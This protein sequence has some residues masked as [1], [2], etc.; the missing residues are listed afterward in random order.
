MI[1]FAALPTA[2]TLS[3]TSNQS[4]DPARAA[5]EASQRYGKLLENDKYTWGFNAATGE[6]QDLVGVGVI[7]P[8]KVGRMGSGHPSN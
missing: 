6:Y 4:D 3:P 2:S 5:F 8:A 1:A 7:D